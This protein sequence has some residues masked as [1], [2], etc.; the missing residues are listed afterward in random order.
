MSTPLRR[1]RGSIT[2][3]NPYGDWLNE[4]SDWRPYNTGDDMILKCPSCG[5][6]VES[7]HLS[8]KPGTR[9]GF[10]CPEC[11][12]T[13]HFSQPYPFFRRTISL[14]LPLSVLWIAG[15]R[16]PA[17]LL[18]GGV[19]LWAPA[20]LLVNGY[21]ARRMPVRLV[22]WDPKDGSPPSLFDRRR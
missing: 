14:I 8:I 3:G 18:I 16:S 20:Q 22:P 1:E 15:V 11:S 21:F 9:G 2:D 12:Q 7:N 5:K 17:W 13:L 6:P 4:G 10:D 19:L